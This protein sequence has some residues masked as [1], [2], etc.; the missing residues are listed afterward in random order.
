MKMSRSKDLNDATY[1]YATLITEIKKLEKVKPNLYKLKLEWINTVL[2]K[3]LEI[4]NA[5][6]G[7]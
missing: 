1:K 7:V 5:E 2:D 4:Q 3:L 6:S